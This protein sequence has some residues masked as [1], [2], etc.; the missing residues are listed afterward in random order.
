MRG[1][2]RRVRSGR[3]D[4][5]RGTGRGRDGRDR[6]RGGRIPPDRVVHR[7]DRA[8]AADAVPGRRG[9]DGDRAPVRAVRR[10]PLRRRVHGGQRGHV[11]ADA[12]PRAAAVGRTGGPAGDQREGP[13][14]VLRHD[15]VPAFRRT[16]GSG[17]D[18]AGFRAVQGRRR[19]QGLD[20]GPEPQEPAALRGY[21]QLQQRLP[22]RRETVD[23]G[24]QRA[25][26]PGPRRPA[27]RRL[28]GGP[29]HPVR[30]YG[31]GCD[32]PLC[33]PGRPQGPEPDRPGPGGDRGRRC[34]ADA[35][36][37]HALGP[38]VGLGAA[39]PE[40][41]GAPER[42]SD[43]VLRPGCH[44]LAGRSPGLPG[45]RVPRRRAAADRDQPHSPDAGRDLAWL[46]PGARRAD[47]GL[48]PHRHRGA[49]G[50]R[51]RDGPDPERPRPRATGLLPAH[52]ARR[53]PRAARRG[54]D[55]RS[56]VRGRRPARCCSPS[57]APPRSA[58]RTN[59]AG[60]WPGRYPNGPSSCSRS[61]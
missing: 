11:V 37:A 58:A 4:H 29:D 18:R 16:A 34:G 9:R 26:G 60:C 10:G 7:R 23:A 39:R 41:V 17:D 35:G 14:P 54:A 28:P 13:G 20:R 45:A 43:R 24:D 42:G 53:R 5:G 19:G 3:G 46:R 55:R 48:Q 44:R 8:G 33:P 2:D 49:T 32:R 56:A 50:L 40:P 31:D 22:D 12:D 47:G 52:R 25:P 59:C 6:A 1:G 27:A 15:R 38:A 21:Q 36:P 30:A 61:T 51:H 57:T